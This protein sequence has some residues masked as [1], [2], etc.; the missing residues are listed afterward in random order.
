MQSRRPKGGLPVIPLIV[1]GL[2][3]GIIAL[4]ALDIFSSSPQTSAEES[5]HVLCHSGITVITRTSGAEENS[6]K[7]G[8]N[9]SR[10][11]VEGDTVSTKELS[12]AT[13]FWPD[14]SVTRMGEKTTVKINRMDANSDRT[15]IHIDFSLAEGKTWSNVVSY[16]FNDSH[17]VERY[18]DD[19]YLAT[20]RGTVFEVDLSRDQKYLHSVS[21]SVTVEDKQSGK[22]TV[23]LEGAVV[24]NANILDRL[25][26]EAL[27]E[28]WNAFNTNQDIAFMLGRLSDLRKKVDELSVQGQDY[29][30]DVRSGKAAFY[31][32]P[33]RSLM[34][35]PS[36]EGRKALTN[37]VKAAATKKD[38]TANL[39]KVY[40]EFHSLPANEQNLK[41]K[42]LLREAIVQNVDEAQ[43][44]DFI[45]DFSRL[46]Y[47][48]TVSVGK[49]ATLQGVKSALD[50]ELEAYVKSGKA[51]GVTEKLFV[52][53][54]S[55]LAK[56]TNATL[57]QTASGA[58]AIL[59]KDPLDNLKDLNAKMTEVREDFSK[60]K[61]DA[62]EEAGSTMSQ[63]IKNFMK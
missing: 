53:G 61:D 47:Y 62:T 35:N 63:F 30:N 51:D 37:Y 8:P 42:M 14:G 46:S 21:H 31:G 48:D 5:P 11:V 40:E 54:N 13:I 45:R 26:Q 50:K 38:A 41:A 33:V 1:G 44:N 60:K 27:D 18:E 2:F 43:K 9:E 4:F 22:S 59:S 10:D 17:F 23:A 16:L 36:T 6:V 32:V 56:D 3:L 28:A 7:F 57:E 24:P 49:D 39:L 34:E 20:V 52:V 15:S 29:A 19:R 12:T 55:S 58:K 25:T